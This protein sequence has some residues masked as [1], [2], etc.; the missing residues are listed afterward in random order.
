[1]SLYLVKPDLTYFEQYKK[2]I[3]NGRTETMSLQK[4]KK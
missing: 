1:M 3:V 2:C 4:S